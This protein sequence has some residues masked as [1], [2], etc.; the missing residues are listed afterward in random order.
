MHGKRRKMLMIV[1]AVTVIAITLWFVRHQRDRHAAAERERAY[2]SLLAQYAGQLKP[3]MTRLEVERY[4]Q[5]NGKR[6]KQMCC[7]VNSKGEYVSLD[8]AGYD[9][10]VKIAEESV[11]FV[12][13]E[14][15]VY[16]AFEFNPK[17]EG[18]LS[19]TNGSDILK[20]VSVYHHLEGCM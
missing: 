12:C 1:A 11:P 7:V 3:G 9:D 15:N 4:L 6:F 18:E 10:L 17:I 13:S 2:Q 20:R 8:R 14:N 5:T 19:D 16:T